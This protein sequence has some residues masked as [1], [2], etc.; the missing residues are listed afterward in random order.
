MNVE[1]KDVHIVLFQPGK[2]VT[3]YCVPSHLIVSAFCF[4]LF[5]STYTLSSFAPTA[6]GGKIHCCEPPS[7]NVHYD[8]LLESYLLL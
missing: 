1:C 8:H 3:V 2:R 7:V 6:T 4:V 5:S